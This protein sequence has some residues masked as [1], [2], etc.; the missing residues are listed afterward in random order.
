MFPVSSEVSV[1][2]L[3]DGLLKTEA[4]RV[5]LENNIISSSEEVDKVIVAPRGKVV[6]IATK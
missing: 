2:E 1:A 6:N 4:I 3:R 5:A